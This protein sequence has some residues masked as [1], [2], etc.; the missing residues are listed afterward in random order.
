MFI[1][2]LI[3]IIFISLFVLCSLKLASEYDK[4]NF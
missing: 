1:L 3:I 2:L 4:D